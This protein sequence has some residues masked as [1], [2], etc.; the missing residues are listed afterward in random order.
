MAG[1]SHFGFIARSAAC[2][3]PELEAIPAILDAGFPVSEGET[4]CPDWIATIGCMYLLP[5]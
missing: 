3:V 1:P 2:C 4:R 5:S